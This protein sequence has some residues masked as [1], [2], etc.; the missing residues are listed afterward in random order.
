[1]HSVEWG[2]EKS[3]PDGCFGS[4]VMAGWGLVF[5]LF[6]LNACSACV[7]SA[8]LWKDVFTVQTTSIFDIRFAL[9][10]C[11]IHYIKI[12]KGLVVVASGART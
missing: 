5:I 4:W 12:V 2:A 3:R 7:W 11:A 10:T 9:W 6:T 8:H 1:V